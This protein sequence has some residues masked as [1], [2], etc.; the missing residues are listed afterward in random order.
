MKVKYLGYDPDVYVLLMFDFL[1]DDSH[2]KR[3]GVYL[4]LFDR[5]WELIWGKK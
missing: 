5:R 2:T 1:T 4:E 3:I